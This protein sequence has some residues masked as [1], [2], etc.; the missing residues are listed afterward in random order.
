MGMMIH[1]NR[2][3]QKERKAAIIEKTENATSESEFPYTKTEIHRMSK[4]DLITLASQIGIQ[5]ADSF[6]GADLKKMLM[7]KVEK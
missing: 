5:E 7:E 3:R 4:E 6:S 2:K 1:R